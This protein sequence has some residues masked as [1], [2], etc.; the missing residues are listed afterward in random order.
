MKIRN[1]FFIFTITLIILGSKLLWNRNNQPKAKASPLAPSLINLTPASIPKPPPTLT[2]TTTPTP[3]P[4]TFSQINRLYGP[5]VHLP[6]LMYH[7]IQTSEQAR[8]EGNTQLTVFPNI[9]HQ[10]M[11]YLKD[12]GY[13]VA[14]MSNLISFF[15]QNTP[16]PPKAVLLTFDDGYD[17]FASNALPV[18]KEFGFRATVFIPTGLLENKGFLSWQQTQSISHNDQILFANHTWSHHSLLKNKAVIKKEISLA[19]QQLQE[20]SLNKPKVFA[21]PYGQSS[22]FAKE[23]LIKKGYKL[24]FTSYH[25][26]T[27]CRQ[28][29]L[30]LPRIRIG[31]TSLKNYGL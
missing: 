24:A 23:F 9:F 31:S 20:H 4:L 21:Y 3:K 10:Q 8:T 30:E 1:L 5:C 15:D 14:T 13:T 27:L 28:K 26:S 11:A 16:L 18:L 19:D 25:G 29:R 12:H 22:K 17:D 2:P 6:T 7:H